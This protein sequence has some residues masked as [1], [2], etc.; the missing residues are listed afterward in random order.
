MEL[1]ISEN[2]KKQKRIAEKK[3][4]KRLE[5]S[6][7]QNYFQDPEKKLSNYKDYCDRN[8]Q[9]LCGVLI[10]ACEIQKDDLIVD[11]GC[12]TGLLVSAF[13]KLGY[14]NIV[15][16]DISYWAIE[17]GKT[18]LDLEKE[19]QHFN[20]NLLIED[21]DWLIMLDVLEHIQTEQELRLLLKLVRFRKGLVLR[22]PVT[23][24][25]G[26][27]YLEVS[28]K[29]ETHLQRHTKNWW[30]D[31]FSSFGLQPI[32]YFDNNDFIWDS[33]GVL[34]VILFKEG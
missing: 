1:N 34:S 25:A 7:E 24:E 23:N 28:E 31:L 16:T 4:L 12:A 30:I 11:Y 22:I 17:Y 14:E 3:W 21:K 15:G 26:K 27:F 10:G 20:R 19:L 8:Y 32:K 9:D 2:D 6:F 29:D 18:K 33:Q 5:L 13:K